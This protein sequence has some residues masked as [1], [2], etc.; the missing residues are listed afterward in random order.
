MDK[1]TY[2]N[3]FHINIDIEEVKL[4]RGEILNNF[5]QMTLIVQLCFGT[6]ATIIGVEMTNLD[7]SGSSL[8]PLIGLPIFFAA[9]SMIRHKKYAVAKIASYLRLSST[10]V[11]KWEI[12]WND[13]KNQEDEIP[14]I[15]ANFFSSN[16]EYILVLVICPLISIGA[17]S[18]P[19]IQN[20]LK[21]GT[22]HF[23]TFESGIIIGSLLLWLLFVVH[24]L[25]DLIIKPIQQFDRNL[26][27][28]WQK[29]LQGYN[30]ESFKIIRPCNSRVVNQSDRQSL[31]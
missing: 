14:I 6:L 30:D 11:F 21:T 24:W 26:D 31:S 2:N 28:A 15:K 13:F 25:V 9:K 4:L 16:L 20:I 3:K 10:G 12:L 18:F 22:L 1:D 19:H 23:A 7:K 5:D 17:A 27:L 8:I 29:T